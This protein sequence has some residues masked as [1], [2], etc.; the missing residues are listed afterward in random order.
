[1]VV[2]EKDDPRIG[3]EI[4]QCIIYSPI[5]LVK[6]KYKRRWKGKDGKWRYEYEEPARD[7]GT[8][9]KSPEDQIYDRAVKH[10]IW[11]ILEAH[12]RDSL[13][14]TRGEFM[15]N[16]MSNLRVGSKTISADLIVKLAPDYEKTAKAKYKLAQVGKKIKGGITMVEVING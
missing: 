10:P 2:T 5:E 9:R 14:S 16:S 13:M 6:A 15:I 4:M 3:T 1:M 7:F 12:V 11:R 8:R